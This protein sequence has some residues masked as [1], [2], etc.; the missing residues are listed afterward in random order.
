MSNGLHF[1]ADA[2]VGRLARWLRLLGFDTLYNPDISDSEL[3]KTAIRD[4]RIIL[5]RDT[6]FLR[7]KNLNSIFF[8]HSDD[9][10]QQIAEV[11]TGFN[12][13]EFGP[14][15]CARCNGILDEAGDKEKIKNVVP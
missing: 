7:R 12:I 3:L 14:G 8:M 4:G 10:K 1:I 9:T 2:M 15:R 6:H 13:N 5:T 11:I